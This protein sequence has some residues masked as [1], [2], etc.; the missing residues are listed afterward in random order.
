MSEE[1]RGQID[2]FFKCVQESRND[3]MK[4]NQPDSDF[5][6]SYISFSDFFIN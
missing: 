6:V 3:C 5:D 1:V 2:E 4:Q